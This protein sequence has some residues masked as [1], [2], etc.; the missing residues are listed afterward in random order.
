LLVTNS[1]I[2][3]FLY[4]LIILSSLC[5]SSASANQIDFSASYQEY[6]QRKGL[7]V[8]KKD[9]QILGPDFQISGD[10][11]QY[12]L[13]TGW[14]FAFGSVRLI[15]E[16]DFLEANQLQYNVRTK[17]G[18]VQK[19]DAI[20]QETFIEGKSAQLFPDNMTLYDGCASTCG[21]EHRHYEI[22][23]KKMVLIPN[24]ALFLTGASFYLAGK[25]VFSMPAYR[26]D[27]TG[28]NPQSPLKIVPG[29]DSARGVFVRSG[30]DFYFHRN[31]YG[32]LNLEPTSRQ[33]LNWDLNL[34]LNQ[35]SVYP[36]TLSLS[37]SYDDFLQNQTLR[38]GLVQEWD[39]GQRGDLQFRLNYLED[40][41]PGGQTNQELNYNL[42]W[43]RYLPKGWR[44]D[45]EVQ[46]RADVDKDKY[47]A[48]N[49]IQNLDLV[50][51]LSLESPTRKIEGSPFR[52]RWGGSY[53]RVKENSFAGRVSSDITEL[54][55]N[56]FQD[57]L[58][59]G[60]TRLNFN[61]QFRLSNYSGGLNREYFRA[62]VGLDHEFGGG[63]R[64]NTI[65]HIHHVDGSNPY[66]TYDVLRSSESLTQR[67]NY[68]KG[69]ISATVLQGQYDFKANRYGAFSSY[70]RYSDRAKGLP[71]FFSLRSSYANQFSPSTLTGLTLDQVFWNYHMENP[72]LWSFDLKG[73]YS[74]LRSRWESFSHEME[75]L[76]KG[77]NRVYL[78]DHY[79]AVTSEFTR[80]R[81]GLIRDFD[82][83]EG[84]V[85]WDFKQK[86]FTIQVY[87]KQG[88][89]D[90]LGFRVDYDQ[91]L[92]VKPELP[93]ID[94]T[95]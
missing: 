68:R 93:G 63:F 19:F 61:S 90:G 67:F 12:N 40:D 6:N 25:K 52:F 49:R 43:K 75:F 74:N 8:L 33:G 58:Q 35:E 14:I 62:N 45:L 22:K 27:L 44:A 57:T 13:K 50:P 2:G 69:K 56:T 37:R 71:Y 85:D 18:R 16:G 65:Y 3:R 84:R 26:I 9:A 28:K 36:S 59:W 10:S 15:R 42:G 24:K 47:L 87:L 38:A 23:A 94:E 1:F 7:I 30:W 76:H 46:G 41:F 89:S 91:V 64:S 34:E 29:Y 86:E 81:L 95:F 73:Q 21:E 88:E 48:D 53:K 83:L 11:L 39:Q 79:N 70:V 20:M 82:C 72:E 92:S 55:L 60:N 17:E 54:M 4:S 32:E 51:S 66:K 77:R 31:V 5:F 80:I 78:Q